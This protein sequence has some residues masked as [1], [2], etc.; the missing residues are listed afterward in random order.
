MNSITG[1]NFDLEFVLSD[2]ISKY[3]DADDK[4]IH[5]PGNEG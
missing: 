2:E 4:K 5:V 1:T 3:E